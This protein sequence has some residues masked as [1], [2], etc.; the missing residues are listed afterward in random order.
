MRNTVKKRE[1]NR[2]VQ[3]GDEAVV[4][5]DGGHQAVVLQRGGVARQRRDHR[6]GARQQPQLARGRDVRAACQTEMG[7]RGKP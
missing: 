6:T 5:D 7:R 3:A 4:L 2:T 1:K